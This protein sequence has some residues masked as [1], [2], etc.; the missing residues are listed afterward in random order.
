MKKSFEV[1]KE[2]MTDLV[3]CIPIQPL[4]KKLSINQYTYLIDQTI[5]RIL[6]T[7][8]FQEIKKIYCSLNS[9]T[10]VR[11]QMCFKSGQFGIRGFFMAT[12]CYQIISCQLATEMTLKF[13]KFV[14]I[15][16]DT[17]TLN[18][19]S[20]NHQSMKLNKTSYRST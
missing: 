6:K 12:L 13:F 7:N 9:F 17:H 11:H 2:P 15:T 10:D 5:E 19:T 14:K 18:W 4:D 16:K 20:A 3:Y 8:K 1:A